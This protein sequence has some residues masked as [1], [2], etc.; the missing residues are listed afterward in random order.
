MD[1]IL[2]NKPAT[3]PPVVFDTLSLQCSDM[4]D[5]VEDQKEELEGENGE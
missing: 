1:A 5:Q 3:K 4:E 2:G